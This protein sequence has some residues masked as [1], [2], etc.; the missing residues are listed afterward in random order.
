VGQEILASN[1]S[2]LHEIQ[3]W[4]KE[5]KDAT[6]EIDYILLH[7]NNLIPI[8]VKQGA[9]GTL[10][11]LH[12]YMD[13]VSHNWAI[14]LYNGPIKIDELKTSSG[15]KFYLLNLPHYLGGKLYEYITWFKKERI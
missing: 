14:R 9:T 8:E 10:K 4:T 3:F 11:S 13:I 5:K 1:F 7:E 6:A 2:V 12:L 15:K